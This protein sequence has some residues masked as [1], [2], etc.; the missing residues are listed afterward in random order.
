MSLTGNNIE[1]REDHDLF[2]NREFSWLAFN[3]RVL[4]LAQNEETPLYER[5]RFLSI[6]AKN[7]DEFYIV[8]I[9]GLKAQILAGI[10][11][12]SHDGLTPV[13]QLDLIADKIKEITALQQSCFVHLLQLLQKENVQLCNAL[14]AKDLE[15]DH[16]WLKRKFLDEIFPMLTPISVDPAHP[17]PFIPNFG[18]SLVLKLYDEK[19]NIHHKALIALPAKTERFIRLPGDTVRYIQIEHLIIKFIHILFPNYK[20]DSYGIFRVL[21]DSEMEIDE[22]AEDLVR[23]F[24]TAL[25]RRRRG[26]VIRLT[27]DGQMS[28]ELQTFLCKQL[29]VAAEDLFVQSRLVGVASVEQMIDDQDSAKLYPPFNPRFPERILDHNGDCFKAIQKKDIL[30]HHP[31]ESFDVVVQFL[32]QAAEDPDVVVIKQTLYRTSDDSPIVKALIHAAESGKAVTAMVE[33]KARFDE[34]KNIRWARDLERAGVQVI[35]G[36][37]GLKIHAKLSLVIRREE[38][39]LKTYVHLG[40]GNYHPINARIY[41]DLS[42]FSCD[43]VMG[44]DI[45]FIFNYMTGYALPQKL[46]KLIISPLRMRETLTSLIDQEIVNAKQKKPAQIWAKMNALV[47]PQLIKKLYEASCAGVQIQ[48]VVRGICC[49]RAGVKDLSENITVKSIVGRYLEHARILCFANGHA[50]PSL[51]ASVYM[52]SADWMPR[53]LDR[54]IETLVPIENPTVKE[55]I[56][57]Q[58]MI[59]NLKDQ[60][61]S[62]YLHKDGKYYKKKEIKDAFSAHDYFMENPSLSGRGNA[63]YQAPMPPRL[64]LSKKKKAKD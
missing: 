25:K 16:L 59:A 14:D 35:Y 17:F 26:H 41:T 60:A 33:L 24:E 40:T 37:A 38:G 56:L 23:T 13:E 53:N 5:V 64:K 1:K 57:N 7:I 21:R 18:F 6:S 54:R 46:K 19:E 49:L 61:S 12:Q 36:V 50:L 62:Q 42:F 10:K 63:L 29:N 15:E 8:R 45:G 47:D 39:V 48:L 44:R 55:Q 2:I 31:Y 27:V 22:E 34:E 20:L 9:A 52:S 28:A 4:E 11:H 30:V 43:E 3:M 51:E 58:I 32:R